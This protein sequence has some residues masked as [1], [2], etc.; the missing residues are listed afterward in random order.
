MLLD[1]LLVFEED[2]RQV[3][4]A[5]FLDMR[6][7]FVSAPAGAVSIAI[8]PA[9]AKNQA[10]RMRYPP[11]SLVVAPDMERAHAFGRAVGSVYVEGNSLRQ[12]PPLG[13]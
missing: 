13:E 9:R 10:F 12:R 6:S 4:Q 11:G 1:Q 2:H 5:E 3:R 8:A 7:V